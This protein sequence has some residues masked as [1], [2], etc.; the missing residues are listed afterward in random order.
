MSTVTQD[1]L[2]RL[3]QDYYLNDA[4]VDHH[5]EHT[6]QL[7][8]APMV[9]AQIPPGSRVLTMGHGN[10]LMTDVLIKGPFSLELVEGSPTLSEEA[11][12]RHGERLGVHCAMFEEFHAPAAY[13]VVLSLHVM[14]H[15]AEPA[16][17]L[18]Q[19]A[20]WLKPGGS[21]IVVVPNR[22]SLHRR[23][24]LRMGLI[25]R[26]DELSPRDHQV[27]HLRVYDLDT[28]AA[29]LSGAGL[30]PEHRFGYFVKTLPN[31]MMLDYS[32]ELLTALVQVG[33]EVPPDL[34]ANIGIRARKPLA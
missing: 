16:V 14:E 17:T 22:R 5:V 25:G 18:A 11:R 7:S 15:V 1:E 10:G 21:L 13:D 26:L 31:S 23:V 29:D 8:S 34:L 32:E 2:E 6:M 4:V 9:L 12:R 33:E 28:L 27:G 19:A 20:S 30:V 24:A 3:A